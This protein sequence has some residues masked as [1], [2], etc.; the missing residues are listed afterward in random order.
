MAAM[1][2]AWAWLDRRDYVV[3]DDIQEVLETVLGHRLVLMQRTGLS[4]RA[5][6]R[7]LLDGIVQ[8]IPVPR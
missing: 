4:R 8:Q 2:R 5:Q 7:K 1:A 3:P 6:M